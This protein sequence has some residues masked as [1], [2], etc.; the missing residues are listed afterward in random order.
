MQASLTRSVRRPAA[1]DRLRDA[2]RVQHSAIEQHPLLESFVGTG[3]DRESYAALLAAFREFY[4]VLEPRLG[5]RLAASLPDSLRY[6]YQWRL[7]LLSRDL[8]DLRFP[9]VT[10]SLPGK[11]V[12]PVPTLASSEHLLGTLYVLEGSTQGGRVIG[13]RILRSLGFRPEHGA[14]YF[15]LY[16]RG[17]WPAYMDLVAQWPATRSMEPMVEGA[18]ETFASLVWHLDHWAHSPFPETTP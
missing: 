16:R 12:R 17:T 1:L 11:G 18:R 10:L 6:C 3:P 14:R 5:S 13:P 7:P 4:R 2:T 8:H 9:F 15:N